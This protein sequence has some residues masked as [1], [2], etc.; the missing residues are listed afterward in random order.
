MRGLRSSLPLLALL[1]A[2]AGLVFAARGADLYQTLEAKTL[3]WRFRRFSDPKLHDPDIV[4]VMLD[5]PSLDAFEKDQVYWPWPRSIYQAALDFFKAGGA[6]AVVFDMLFTSPSPYGGGE[7]QAFG[8]SLKGFGP[9]V[10]A[11]EMSGT[12]N[13]L[14]SAAPPERFALERP[15]PAGSAFVERSSARLPI[16]E[17]LNA[18]PRLGDTSTPADPDGVFR[19]LPL[20]SR[21]GGRL[22][23]SAALAAAMAATGRPAESFRVPLVDGR[24]LVRFHGSALAPHLAAGLKTYAA[25][26]L[27]NVI[28]SWQR[29]QDKA[30]PLYQPS[31]FKDKIVFIGASAA[32][33]LDNRPSPIAP[34][35]PGTEVLASAADNLIHGDALD[36]AGPA[37]SFLLILL[38]VLAAAGAVRLTSS[39]AASLAAAAAAS[40]A[41]VAA[42]AFAFKRALWIDLAGPELGL[43][44][45]FA[46]VSAYSYAVEG[47]KKKEI[48]AAFGHYLSPAVVSRIAENPERLALG[49]DRRD[50]TVHFSDIEGF[51]TISEGLEPDRLTYLMNRYLGAMTDTILE[52]GGTLDKYIGDAVMA[53]W[54]A[55]EPRADHALAACR[56]A[57]ANQQLLAALR[58]EFEKEGFPPVRSRIG[59]NSGPASIGNMGSAKRFSYTAIG[60]N[61]NLASRLE[62]ANKAYGTYT[63]ISETTREQAGQAIEVRELDFIKVKGKNV[64]IRVYELIGLEGETPEELIRRARRFEEGLALY[65]SRRWDEAA[66]AFKSARDDFKTLGTDKASEAYVERCLHFK[67]EPP[68]G[69]WDGSYTMTEK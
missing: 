7:D 21:M 42:S 64:P 49:G 27:G 20:A 22:Y 69:D 13:P 16:P 47:R 43:W 68:P 26:S 53:F 34:V 9:V 6:R 54:G 30:E 51:T 41:L 52:S 56:V 10:L 5:Q 23:P 61:V 66:S 15:G 44:L 38:A 2:L 60:D 4:L 32:G 3:D 48:Q 59:L 12:P 39:T 55:P 25:Y 29:L 65:R 45:G 8:E 36:K 18:V 28:L 58:K 35:F 33:L 24:M 40:A 1:A 11:M 17:L 63:M 62:G 67:A 31:L 19:R 57:V 46:A 14:R 50:V 37:A